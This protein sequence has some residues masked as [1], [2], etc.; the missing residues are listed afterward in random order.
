MGKY[1]INPAGII[2]KIYNTFGVK[3][4]NMIAEPKIAELQTKHNP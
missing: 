4:I 3:H 2:K 1:P